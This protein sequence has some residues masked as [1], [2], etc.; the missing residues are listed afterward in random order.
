MRK[1]LTAVKGSDGIYGVAQDSDGYFAFR[2]KVYSV[3]IDN[4]DIPKGDTVERFWE[5]RYISKDDATIAVL[6]AN[7]SLIRLLLRGYSVKEIAER[8]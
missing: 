7:A 6:L 1:I 5:E 4:Y 3:V 2:K 8:M